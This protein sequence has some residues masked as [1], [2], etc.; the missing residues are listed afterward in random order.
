MPTSPDKCLKC[1]TNFTLTAFAN[2]TTCQFSCQ[3][4]TIATGVCTACKSGFYLNATSNLCIP[5]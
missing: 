1:K 4:C 5:C 2:C 3:T